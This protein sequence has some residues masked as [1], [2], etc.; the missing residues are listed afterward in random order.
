MQNIAPALRFRRTGRMAHGSLA[1][2]LLIVVAL[3]AQK[4]DTSPVLFSTV[5][6]RV[7]AQPEFRERVLTGIRDVPKVGEFLSP[8]LIE[9]LRMLILGKKWQRVASACCTARIPSSPS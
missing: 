1:L 7:S 4:T 2:V 9:R 8:N 5:M 6:Q 3:A